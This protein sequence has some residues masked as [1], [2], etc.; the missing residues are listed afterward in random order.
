MATTRLIP[1]HT[2]KDRSVGTAIRDIT[3]TAGILDLSAYV[4]QGGTLGTATPTESNDVYDIEVNT[5]FRTRM[6]P[7]SPAASLPESAPRP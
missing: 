2:G 6:I 1:L 7:V 5:S 4:A 3:G